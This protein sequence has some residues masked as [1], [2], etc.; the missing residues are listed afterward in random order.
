MFLSH[1]SRIHHYQVGSGNIRPIPT[2]FLIFKCLQDG[3]HDRGGQ[4]RAGGR[5]RGE[6]TN[7]RTGKDI[8]KNSF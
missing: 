5:R 7:T 2:G 8:L 4:G 6:Q 3:Q 1:M